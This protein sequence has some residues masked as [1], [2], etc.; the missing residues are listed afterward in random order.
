MERRWWE[1]NA[2]LN[3]EA[4]LEQYKR[5]DNCCKIC[6]ERGEL[7]M[8][9][10]TCG[11]SFH[12]ACIGLKESDL[13]E[14]EWFCSECMAARKSKGKSSVEGSN[15]EQNAK[16]AKLNFKETTSRC[17]ALLH[18]AVS[19]QQL[20][21]H[22]VP[23]PN[24]DVATHWA[25]EWVCFSCSPDKKIFNECGENVLHSLLRI[26]DVA[27]GAVHQYALQHMEE[28]CPARMRFVCSS[29]AHVGLSS[30]IHCFAQL[31]L[32]CKKM[33]GLKP[34]A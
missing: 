9:D 20:R 23:A 15:R 13:P 12:L 14:G 29:I 1:T 6:R 30:C 32:V 18:G 27:H 3:F 25:L 2:R 4:E 5:N 17:P 24:A 31:N 28:V 10:G 11:A 33:E 26:I 19:P 34:S 21:S 8:C 22:S 16:D 7:L